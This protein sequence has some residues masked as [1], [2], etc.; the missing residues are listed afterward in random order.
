MK[1][2]SLAFCAALPLAIPTPAGTQEL[3]AE[4]EAGKQ[5]YERTG[6]NGG[7]IRCH[8]PDAMGNET[9]V[10]YSGNN[11]QGQ[12]AEETRVA[13]MALPMMWNIKITDEEL[14]NVEAYLMHLLE[15][16]D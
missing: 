9:D 5:I 14:A 6:N 10:S 8:G 12:T 7:C 4:I 11:I 16:S 2:I 13:I 1:L 15:A 3:D